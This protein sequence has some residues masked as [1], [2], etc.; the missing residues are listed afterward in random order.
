MVVRLQYVTYTYEKQETPV[1]SN[2]NLE[3]KQGEFVSIIG[4]SGTGKSTIFK[5]MTGL[6]SPDEGKIIIHGQQ[7]AA[8]EVGYMPQKDLL[9]PW[10]TIL[11]NVM[12][13]AEIQKDIALTKEEAITW[14]ERV[15]LKDYVQAFPKELSGGMRQR[16]AC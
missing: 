9:L 16:A 13:A 5:L 12:L 14:I 6:L 11:E 15:G 2:L 4:R 7:A 10:R 1:I 3:I 8:G